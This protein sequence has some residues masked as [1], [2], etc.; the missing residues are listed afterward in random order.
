MEELKKLIDMIKIEYNKIN[1]LWEKENSSLINLR[2]KKVKA[3][4][5]DEN[6]FSYISKYR[7]F[8]NEKGVFLSLRFQKI[9]TVNQI[10]SRVKNINSVQYKIQNYIE[11]HSNGEIAINKCLNDLFGIRM[12]FKDSITFEEISLFIKQN[13]PELKCLNSSKGE[14]VA[15]HIYFGKGKNSNFQWELQIWDKA[16]EE[17]N[18]SSHAEYKQGYTKWEKE[19]EEGGV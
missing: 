10:S 16:H 7:S 4:Y 19:N 1:E 11:T 8:I 15:T 14:Y 5:C 17:S 13:F 2:S 12:I 9:A 6:L 3:I 18:F